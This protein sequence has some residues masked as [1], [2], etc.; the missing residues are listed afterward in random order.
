MGPRK[1]HANLW[2]AV[3]AAVATLWAVGAFAADWPQFLGQARNG[4][5]AETGLLPEW[6]AGGPPLVWKIDGLG[7]GYSDVS[8]SQG[9]VFTMG[10][11]GGPSGKQQFVVALDAA[12]GK[13]LW[14]VDITEQTYAESHGNGPRGTPTVD[15]DKLYAEAADG[16]LVCLDVKTGKK[17]WGLNFQT[18]FH[19]RPPKW[20]FSE[21]PLVEG[22]NLIVTPGAPD[23]TMVALDKN[24]GKV[25]WKSA[26]GDSAGYSSPI[27]AQV[28]DIRHFIQ[29]TAGGV[30]GVRADNGKLLWRYQRVANRVANIATPIYRDPYVFVSTEYDTGCALLKLTNEGGTIKATEVYFNRDMQ[31]KNSNAVLQ[32]NWLY[33]FNHNILVAMNLM[34]GEV[35][36]KDR[37]VGDNGSVTLAEGKLYVLGE[38]GNV[39]LVEASAEHYKEISRFSITKSSWPAYPPLVISNGKMFLREEDNLFCYNI[40]N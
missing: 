36:W 8:V 32:G 10:Q 33:G 37:S 19:A 9:R 30:V 3:V 25:V 6:P 5:S 12:T 40:K 14:H 20:A 23:A 13:T 35:A 1:L 18:D 11:S 2:A 34:T 26:I 7:E 22:E 31:N 29:L 16:T 27:V 4:S 24:T 17:I 21:S 39:A 28:G 38:N 15:G